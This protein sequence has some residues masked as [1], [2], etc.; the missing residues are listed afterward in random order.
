MKKG[1]F[2]LTAMF[3]IGIQMSGCKEKPKGPVFDPSKVVLNLQG[4][5]VD[6]VE[7]KTSKITGEIHAAG[8]AYDPQQK[9]PSKTVVIVTEG[10]P[11]PILP[12]MEV[13]RKD[14]AQVL[15]TEA[16]VKWG[17]DT[18]FKADFLGKG[19]H[20]LE[21]YALLENGTFV[22]LMI[23]GQKFCDIEILD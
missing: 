12:K 9:V 22:P 11:L 4:G 15:N 6:V 17:W 20:R 2:V 18:T 5:F 14:V 13:E 7:P 1:L 10:K 8:W 23:D 19:K 21:F 16:S 3:L